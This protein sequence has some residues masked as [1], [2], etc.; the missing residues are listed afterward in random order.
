MSARR[1]AGTRRTAVWKATVWVIN[2]RGTGAGVT[3]TRMLMVRR[4]L[5]GRC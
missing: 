4:N 2:A 3:G 1:T 5:G